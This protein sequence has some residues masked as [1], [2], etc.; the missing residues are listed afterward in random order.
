[1][2]GREE[3]GKGWGGRVSGGGERG[4]KGKGIERIT[5]KGMEGEER[6]S[7]GGAGE[8]KCFEEGKGMEGKV[9]R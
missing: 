8:E 3:I 9:N 4:R 1:M 5:G 6:V 7:K 2:A